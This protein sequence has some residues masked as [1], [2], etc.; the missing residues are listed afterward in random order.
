[1]TVKDLKNVR[2]AVWDARTKWMDIGL[3]LDLSIND[4]TAIEKVHRG[5]VDM[6]FLQMLNLWLKQGDPRPTW[7]AMIDALKE[8]VIGF[9]QLAEEVESKF[10]HQAIGAT[11]EYM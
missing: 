8:P 5:N 2:K 9:Q 7:S 4:L 11:G 3:E 10:V 6:C 1:M